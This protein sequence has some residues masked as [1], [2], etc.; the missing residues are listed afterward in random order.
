MNLW[1]ATA[2]I[3]NSAFINNTAKLGGAVSVMEGGF[4]NIEKCVFVNNTSQYG[5]AVDISR[6]WSYCY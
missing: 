6:K 5:A 2:N 1:F 3:Y 4:A